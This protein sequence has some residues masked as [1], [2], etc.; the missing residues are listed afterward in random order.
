[1]CS[2]SILWR[3]T[4]ANVHSHVTCRGFQ[5]YLMYVLHADHCRHT[6]TYVSSHNRKGN[7]KYPPGTSHYKPSSKLF[8]PQDCAHSVCIA[9]PEH[10]PLRTHL[11][12][13]FDNRLGHGDRLHAVLPRHLVVPRG[14][15]E[16]M[17][18]LLSPLACTSQSSSVVWT[19]KLTQ[20][21]TVGAQLDRH[22][23]V[24]A[25]QRP[26]CS[27][28]PRGAQ[29][30]SAYR[31]RFLIIIP[32][33]IEL[34][35]VCTRRARDRRPARLWLGRAVLLAWG[36]SAAHSPKCEDVMTAIVD[37]ARPRRPPLLRYR[38]FL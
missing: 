1:M 28:L 32:P 2:A 19:F 20:H 30:V 37:C 15:L 3:Q 5:L 29:R 23:H 10:P 35:D 18:S 11:R 12:R 26:H 27:V 36:M 31:T 24:P 7:P 38:P 25:A 14:L 13:D 34:V 33:V 6:L 9:S 16:C 21:P 8:K 4:Y 17:A 22:V